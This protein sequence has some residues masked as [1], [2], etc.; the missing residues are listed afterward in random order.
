MRRGYITDFNNIKGVIGR[1][2]RQQYARSDFLQCL[3]FDTRLNSSMLSC[4]SDI[5]CLRHNGPACRL[6]FA[7]RRQYSCAGQS[8]RILSGHLSNSTLSSD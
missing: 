3:F 8:I 4:M 1:H 6:V 7:F 2:R 5:R